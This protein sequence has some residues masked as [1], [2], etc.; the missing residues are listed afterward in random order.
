MSPKVTLKEP[1]IARVDDVELN[2]GDDPVELSDDQIKRLRAAG[3]VKLS[4]DGESTSE[5]D[6]DE[7]EDETGSDEESNTDSDA[8]PEEPGRRGVLGRGGDR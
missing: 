1:Q 8:E 3:G 5:D 4:M 2:V 6:A 7:S